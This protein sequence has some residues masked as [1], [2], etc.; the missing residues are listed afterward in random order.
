M[1]SQEALIEIV[2]QSPLSSTT[3]DFFTKKIQR[4]GAT[5]ENIVALREL[6]R[7]VQHHKFTAA[8]FTLDPSNPKLEAA[9][10]QMQA[11]LADAGNQYAATMKRL[12]VAADRLTKDIQNDLKHLEDIVV[13]SAQA[14]A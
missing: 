11:D 7:A 3:R 8:G 4:E 6:L 13:K 5:Q 10:E 12:E 1:P 9:S 2:N 14:E